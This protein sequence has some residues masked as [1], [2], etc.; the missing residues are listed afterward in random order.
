VLERKNHVKIG[1]ETMSN[2]PTTHTQE[3]RS[4]ELDRREGRKTVSVSFLKSAKAT[5]SKDHLITYS[6]I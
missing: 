3:E 5:T 6:M 2:R 1:I 4:E